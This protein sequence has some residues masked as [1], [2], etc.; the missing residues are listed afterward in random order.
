MTK[1]KN[2][3][4]QGIK[5]LTKAI[6]AK[7]M[8]ELRQKEEEINYEL[9]LI[10]LKR[11]AIVS[12]IEN[13]KQYDQKNKKALMPFFTDLLA[14]KSEIS[15]VYGYL[16]EGLKTSDGKP[17]FHQEI[18]RID[19]PRNYKYKAQ[20]PLITLFS[21]FRSCG[22]SYCRFELGGGHV[23]VNSIVYNLSLLP[24][25]FAVIQDTYVDSNVPAILKDEVNEF[26][27]RVYY[28]NLPDDTSR[29]YESEKRIQQ[30]RYHWDIEKLLEKE[31]RFLPI[32]VSQLEKGLNDWLRQA[33]DVIHP[34]KY[35]YP[36]GQVE[37]NER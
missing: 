22:E 37:E 20:Y 26:A 4:I 36:T 9:E 29:W 17:E 8:A 24:E 12:T 32:D 16:R 18:I 28:V 15:G 25:G 1:L 10:R 3:T 34:N 33:D 2:E 21:F 35:R 30:R 5:A 27:K 23:P 31:A 13:L 11:G 14:M 19:G 7:R 6:E